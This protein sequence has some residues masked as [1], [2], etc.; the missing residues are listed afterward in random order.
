MKEKRREGELR[1]R[2]M[3]LRGRFMLSMSIALFFMLRGSAVVIYH[4]AQNICSRAWEDSLKAGAK[5]SYDNPVEEWQFSGIQEVPGEDRYYPASGV[6][7]K[8]YIDQAGGG[9]VYVYPLDGS[10]FGVPYVILQSENPIE[11]EFA[12]ND[13]VFVSRS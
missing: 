5:M 12:L 9:T 10:N 1:I 13:D 8:K 2:G 6:R 3:G 7:T 11:G 4:L